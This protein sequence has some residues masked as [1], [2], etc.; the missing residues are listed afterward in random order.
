MSAEGHESGAEYGPDVLGPTRSADNLYQLLR[1]SHLFSEAVKTALEQAALDQLGRETLGSKQLRL[2]RL[3][4]ETPRLPVGDAA[5]ELGITPSGVTKSMSGLERLGLAVR[6]PVHGDRRC[7]D[8]SAS[9]AGYETV[10]DYEELE[11]AIFRRATAGF[12]RAE[13]QESCNLLSRLVVAL[14]RECPAARARCLWCGARWDDDCVLTAERGCCPHQL[15]K[16]HGASTRGSH[17][18]RRDD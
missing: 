15:D 7:V 5:L 2:L 6:L 3:L 16:R 10:R 18:G 12:N 1:L 9:L 14:F 4:R 13:V 8:L 11:S 17:R